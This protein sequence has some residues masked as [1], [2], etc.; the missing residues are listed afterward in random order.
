MTR[1]FVFT[2]VLALL[3]PLSGANGGTPPVQGDA[4]SRDA[5]PAEPDLGP[6]SEVLRQRE[7]T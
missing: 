1:S 4:A 3:T 6:M 5:A 2:L 7:G